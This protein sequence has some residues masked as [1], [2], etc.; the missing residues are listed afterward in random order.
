MVVSLLAAAG[1]IWIADASGQTITP[2]S[3]VLLA[4]SPVCSGGR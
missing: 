3:I 1:L 2:P 4:T